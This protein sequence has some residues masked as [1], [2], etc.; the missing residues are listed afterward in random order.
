MELISLKLKFTVM[1]S[2]IAQSAGPLPSFW[3]R[4]ISTGSKVQVTTLQIFIELPL[5]STLQKT[6]LIT[7]ILEIATII[8]LS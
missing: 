6:F 5:V 8:Y 4:L 7:H 2:L 3:F 1:K